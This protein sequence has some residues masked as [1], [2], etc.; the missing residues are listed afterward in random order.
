MNG[1]MMLK[2]QNGRYTTVAMPREADCAMAQ[3]FHGTRTEVT[4]LESSMVRDRRRGS[5]PLSR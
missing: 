3:V 5:S 4:V 2:K 1:L